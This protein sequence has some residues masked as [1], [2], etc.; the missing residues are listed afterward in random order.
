MEIRKPNN[1]FSIES[2][3]SIDPILQ[4]TPKT[5]FIFYWLTYIPYFNIRSPERSTVASSN[6][7]FVGLSAS[8]FQFSPIVE[9]FLQSWSRGATSLPVLAVDAKTPNATDAPDLMKVGFYSKIKVETIFLGCSS[10]P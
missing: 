9:H 1:F 10:T 8:I 7:R 5:T 6:I 3:D 2:H 4:F